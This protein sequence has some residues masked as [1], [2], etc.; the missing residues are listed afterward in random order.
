MPTCP[1]CGSIIMKGDP[2]CSHC[3]AHLSW[4]DDSSRVEFRE[5]PKTN[6]EKIDEII[7]A[8]HLS[9]KKRR[10]LKE[11][12]MEFLNAKDCNSLSVHSMQDCY[13]FVFTRENEYV[14]TK[15]EFFYDPK[16]DKD[17]RVFSD[18][19]DTHYHDRLLENPRFKELVKST[20]FEFLGCRGGYVTEYTWSPD[21]FRMIDRIDVLVYFRVDEERMRYYHLDLDKMKLDKDYHEWSE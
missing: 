9:N 21:E 7:N 20:G 5:K 17:T 11:K 8:M 1:D 3:G 15:D 2:Y 4:S 14:K 6:E 10:I 19:G 18:S 12:T 13:I 16:D